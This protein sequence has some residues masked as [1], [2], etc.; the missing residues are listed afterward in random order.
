MGPSQPTMPLEQFAAVTALIDAGRPRSEVLEASDLTPQAWTEAQAGWLAKMAQEARLRRFEL[1]SRFN[2]MLLDHL[3]RLEAGHKIEVAPSV[4]LGRA[5]EAHRI[6]EPPPGPVAE[7]FVDAPPRAPLAAPAF[8]PP[9]A[10]AALPEPPARRPDTAAPP[11]SAGAAVPAFVAPPAPLPFREVARDG[12]LPFASSPPAAAPAPPP[13][14]GALPFGNRRPPAPA[15]LAETTDLEALA[16][17]LE[18]DAALPFL[19]GGGEAGSASPPASRGES[20]GEHDV[21]LPFRAQ[22]KKATP[23]PAPPQIDD[24][25]SGTLN[26]SSP[27]GPP[28]L[29]LEQFASLEAELRCHPDRAGAVRARYGMNAA[30]FAAERLR[31][32]HRFLGDAELT[33]RYKA[34]LDEF[35]RWL[36]ANG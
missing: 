13:H 18:L 34:K 12:A 23:L 7:P 11:P 26:V 32:A 2:A 36:E 4:A 6:S 15:T 5:G 1:Q 16:A 24:D 10:R 30:D 21:A 33:Q 20:P 17:Q 27:E 9:V 19:R 14:D 25:L 29:T 35:I 3:R 8:A 31:W 28:R 22:G